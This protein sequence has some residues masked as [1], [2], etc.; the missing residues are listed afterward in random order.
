MGP[1][2]DLHETRQVFLAEALRHSRNARAFVHG[3]LQNRRVTTRQLADHHIAQEAHHLTSK[4]RWAVA[5]ADEVVN[6]T[7]A[8]VVCGGDADLTDTLT[9]QQVLDLE[10]AAFMRLVKTPATLARIEHVLETGRPLR[11]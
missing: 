6:L 11:N 1:Q 3:N 7:L 5:I 9:E 10:R 4:V 2:H 8:E